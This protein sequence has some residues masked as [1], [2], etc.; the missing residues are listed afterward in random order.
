MFKR[1]IATVAGATLAFGGVAVAAAPAGASHC[2]GGS[3]P[4][5]VQGKPPSAQVGN[6]GLAL[7]RDTGG[8]WHFRASEAGADPAVFKGQI[9]TNGVI[10]AVDS[11][12]EGGDV[13]YAK[14][15]HSV[16][17]RFVNF[18]YV[19]GL[20]FVV[21]CASRIRVSGTMN[22]HY[23]DTGSIF[24]G[25]GDVHPESNPFAIVKE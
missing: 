7:W 17:Y 3:W 11:H 2:P 14:T 22:G 13:N 25:D 5:Y 21:R 18:G 16:W 8:T 20:D 9:S 23:V 24:I 4:D 19:D 15:R 1:L 12:L 10:H 6:T